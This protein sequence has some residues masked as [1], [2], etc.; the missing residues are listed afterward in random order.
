MTL[1]GD[2]LDEDLPSALLRDW[3]ATGKLHFWSPGGGPTLICLTSLLQC[4]ESDDARRLSD[5][6]RTVQEK[7][8]GK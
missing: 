7:G 1:T 6:K 5:P 4:F 3:L 2:G 8:E